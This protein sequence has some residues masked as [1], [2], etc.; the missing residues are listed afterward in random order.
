MQMGGDPEGLP[1]P[2]PTGTP[3]VLA[4]TPVSRKDTSPSPRWGPGRLTPHWGSARALRLARLGPRGHKMAAGRA[5]GWGGGRLTAGRHQRREGRELLLSVNSRSGE[6]TW[7]PAGVVEGCGAISR[8]KLKGG[9]WWTQATSW[10]RERGW[11]AAQAALLNASLA[12][13]YGTSGGMDPK[14]A[15]YGAMLWGSSR[16]TPVAPCCCSH[17]CQLLELQP[18]DQA[19]TVSAGICWGSKGWGAWQGYTSYCSLKCASLPFPSAEQ[20]K[21]IGKN[22][23]SGLLS[24]QKPGT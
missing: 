7:R 16:S 6:R 4:H 20:W 21:E 24:W 15:L 5:R 14:A 13:D 23:F 17:V 10:G 3:P 18:K 11:C 8:F 2:S 19:V 12:G 22:T 1:S 9:P